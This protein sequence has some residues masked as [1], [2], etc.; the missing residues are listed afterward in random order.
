MIIL[1]RTRSCTFCCAFHHVCH[2][3]YHVVIIALNVNESRACRFFLQILVHAGCMIMQETLGFCF[4]IKH[5][6][7]HRA[8]FYFPCASQCQL[9]LWE[10]MEFAYMEVRHKYVEFYWLDPVYLL[11]YLLLAVCRGVDGGGGGVG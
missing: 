9:G 11:L 3:I 7:V 8:F 6:S 10:L 2:G 4:C 5:P 1:C